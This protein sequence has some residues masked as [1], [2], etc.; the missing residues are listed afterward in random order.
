MLGQVAPARV[1]DGAGHCLQQGAVGLRHHV[2]AQHKD[3][4]APVQQRA[5]APA[6]HHGQD[7]LLAPLRVAAAVLVQDHQIHQQPLKPPVLV[8]AQQ[9]GHQHQVVVHAN[10]H[11]HQREVAG[12]AVGPQRGL[13]L[14]V[15]GD[16][17]GPRA[18]VPI[19]EER[20]AREPLEAVCLV[21][22]HPNVAQLHLA[23][24]PRQ[25]EHAHDRRRVVQ[26]VGHSQRLGAALGHPRNERNLRAAAR[27]NPHAPPQA[28]RR[29][30]HRAAMA[31]QRA[32]QRL[33]VGQI[34][35][36]AYKG[37]PVALVL[38]GAQR[39]A[40]HAQAMHG[41]HL[42]G[43]RRARAAR[44][45]QGVVLGH[46]LGLHKQVGKRGVRLVGARRGQH[47]LA[48]A[49]QLQLARR[50]RQV[51]QRHAPQLGVLLGRDHNLHAGVDPGHLLAELGL[52]QPVDHLV[53]V[54]VVASGLVGGA[55]DSAAAGVAHIDVAAPV[56]AGHIRAP[57]RHGQVVER[58]GA[59]A[60]VGQHHAVVP[61]RE[62][63]RVGHR[64]VRRGELA[65]RGRLG[66]VHLRLARSLARPLERRGLRHTLLKQR[67]G[68][69]H[70]RLGVEAALH[71]VAMQCIAEGQQAH[72][73][74]VG[75]VRA[76]Q[77][78]ALPWRQAAGR[79]VGGLVQPVGAEHAVVDHGL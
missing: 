37:R 74:V 11:Q 18:T 59:A 12:D 53:A 51:R 47:H 77:R 57:A 28:Q 56:V 17:I 66:E 4:A 2:A 35:P 73:L 50:R 48:V 1:E 65:R 79:V 75:H 21:G 42:A 67:L 45:Q 31:A 26:A 14:A 8:G 15:G 9:L 6:A 23:L 33:R 78:A 34:A 32:M 55:P 41:P 27:H 70:A 64:R 13:P 3:A 62:Q 38:H 49:R 60:R 36:T 22:V 72:A 52:V 54:R 24:G 16:D 7:L 29:V 10:A 19:Q 20:G 68:G 43:A 71:Q 40:A 44:G 39:V 46:K 58:A 61:V 76:D 25:L 30:E 69:L 5:A 63:V